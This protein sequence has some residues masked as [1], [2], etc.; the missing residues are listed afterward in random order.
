MCQERQHNRLGRAG[1]RTAGLKRGAKDACKDLV[2]RNK[3]A[4]ELRR[5]LLPGTILEFGQRV[6]KKTVGFP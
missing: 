3:K 5:E 6:I 4:V 1:D 2:A